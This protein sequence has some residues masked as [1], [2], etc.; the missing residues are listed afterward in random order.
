MRNLIVE[1]L[2]EQGYRVLQAEDGPQGLAILQSEQPVDLLL[3][4]VGLP[5]L[6]GRQLA[7]AC[8]TGGRI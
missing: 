8:A 1:M 6:N 5:G 3:T 2:H 4:D 7:D